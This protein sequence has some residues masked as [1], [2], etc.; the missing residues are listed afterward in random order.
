MA[1]KY[2]DCRDHPGDVK[3]SVAFSAD[4]EDELLRAVFQHAKDVHGYPDTPEVQTQLR[5]AIREGH[6]RV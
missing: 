4:S 1:R 5:E 2:I 3:C 6:P